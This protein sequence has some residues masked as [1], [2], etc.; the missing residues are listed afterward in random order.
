VLRD[1]HSKLLLAAGSPLSGCRDAE[2]AEAMVALFGLRQH[3]RYKTQKIVVELECL[4]VAS[5][6]CSKLEDRSVHCFTINEAKKELAVLGDHRIDHVRR[7]STQVA[8]AIA[9][10]SRSTMEFLWA[11][12]LPSLLDSIVTRDLYNVATDGI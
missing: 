5:A 3:Q 12:N 8:N 2:E 11:D 4:N 1:H 6:L 10:F 7:E 9:K